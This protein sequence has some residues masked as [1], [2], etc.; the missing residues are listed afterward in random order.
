MYVKKRDTPH[1]AAYLFFTAQNAHPAGTGTNRLSFGHGGIGLIHWNRYMEVIKR[2]RLIPFHT[3]INME[4]IGVPART[5]GGK[6]FLQCF[7]HA[8]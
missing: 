8:I 2:E 5:G 7:L 6:I 4:R 3:I 1:G